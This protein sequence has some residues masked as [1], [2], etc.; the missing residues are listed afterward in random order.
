MLTPA[1]R[2]QQGIPSIPPLTMPTD[3]LTPIEQPMELPLSQLESDWTRRF[4]T[5]LRSRLGQEIKPSPAPTEIPIAT[6]SE[7]PTMVIYTTQPM[8]KGDSKIPVGYREAVE[9]G[10]VIGSRVIIREQEVAVVTGYGSIITR[11]PILMR[12]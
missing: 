8:R 6:P 1:L 9:M 2:E 4:R 5:E 7:G 11:D 3:M 10:A 12:L